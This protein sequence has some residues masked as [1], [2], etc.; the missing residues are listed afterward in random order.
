MNSNG[1]YLTYKKIIEDLLFNQ[2]LSK[3]ELLDKFNDRLE[4]INI[5]KR[6]EKVLERIINKMENEDDYVFDKR[7]PGHERT[8]TILSIPNDVILT[9]EEKLAFPVM[10][11]LMPS[12]KTIPT[13]SKIKKLIQND[14]GL[15]DSEIETGKF[16]F[17]SEPEINNHRKIILLAG[18]LIDFAK[19][20]IA[21]KY[22]YKNKSGIEDF[23]FIAPLQIRLYDHRYYLLGLDLDENNEPKDILKNYCLD[24]FSNYEVFGADLE[25]EDG[26]NSDEPIRFNHEEY[27]KKSNLENKLTNSIGIWYDPDN[28]LITY[29]L[30]FYDWAKGHVLNRKL[31]HSQQTIDDID[32]YVIIR[33]T[34][35]DNFEI[36][37]ILNRYGAACERL[38]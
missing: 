19:K 24:T 23:K 7:T 36:D 17:K 13:V 34:V 15:D 11:G 28:H 2:T 5:S 4:T 38:N 21:I 3:K 10:I 20:G 32:N 16:F 12:E 6:K 27:Y 26:A 8:Y 33:I 1:I 29:R 37:Y 25:T 30:K 22:V 31:H 18:K 35:W 9:D 14:Y